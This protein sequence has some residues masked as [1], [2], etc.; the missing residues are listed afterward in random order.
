[1][2]GHQVPDQGLQLHGAD[3]GRSAGHDDDLQEHVWQLRRRPHHQAER[4]QQPAELLSAV[5]HPRG[6]GGPK[7]RVLGDEYLIVGLK[8]SEIVVR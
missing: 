8:C 4:F 7:V 5:C 2:S 3:V 1:M 6:N